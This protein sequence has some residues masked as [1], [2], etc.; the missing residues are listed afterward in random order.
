[1]RAS[2]TLCGLVA[3]TSWFAK[4]GAYGSRR[5][6][7]ARTAF[8]LVELLVVIAIIG[9]L[10]AL[11][12][13]AVQAAREAARRS[14]CTNNL[15]QIGLALHNYHNSYG[16]FPPASTGP[17][18]G[19]YGG[20]Y[21]LTLPPPGSRA[22]TPSGHAFSWHAMLLPFLEQQSL[23][24][25]IDFRRATWNDSGYSAGS[26]TGNALAAKTELPGLRCP[27]FTEAFTS[28]AAEYD[29]SAVWSRP[30]LTNYVGLG[31]SVWGKLTSGPDGI[32]VAPTLGRAN[33]TRFAD[34]K[35][36]TS[37]TVLC[38]ETKERRYAAWWDGSTSVVV[39]ML[40]P[41]PSVDSQAALNRTVYMTQSDLNGS[42][43]MSGFQTDWTWGP[44]SEHAGG[45]NHAL[46]DG[47]VRFIA[48]AVDA[49]TYRAL[50]TR[51]GG[52]APGQL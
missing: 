13:P 51:S 17:L 5:R 48:E 4:R 28:E 1:M 35:D 22:G 16:S 20:T 33:P 12:L 32:L 46:G 25:S 27:S 29:A 19:P 52:E 47:S 3:H 36:G 24:V 37:N 40:R 30:A 14:Q 50:A 41:S 34:I 10:I 38:V 2:A 15:K 43:P 8:T 21:R 39:A 42:A 26:P 18:V 49:A 11:L 44:S 23:L 7:G 31:A 45:A 9:V 6:L